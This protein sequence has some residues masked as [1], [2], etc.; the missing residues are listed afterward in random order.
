MI[1]FKKTTDLDFCLEGGGKK[2]A[3]CNFSEVQ[4]YC[5]TSQDE[6]EKHR[7]EAGVKV[8]NQA[9]HFFRI[10]HVFCVAWNMFVDMVVYALPHELVSW[11]TSFQHMWCID[12][13][14]TSVAL[15]RTFGI[16]S[17]ALIICRVHEVFAKQKHVEKRYHPACRMDMTYR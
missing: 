2:F 5:S 17:D 1:G 14:C 10:P 7:A 4:T 8:S 11:C 13:L 16:S 3:C 12:L 9:P 6:A 15:C